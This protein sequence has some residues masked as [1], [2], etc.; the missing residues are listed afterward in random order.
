MLVDDAMLCYRMP[1]F[2]FISLVSYISKI[3]LI[4]VIFFDFSTG[5]KTVEMRF[6]LA[7]APRVHNR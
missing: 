6:C 4:F 1:L 5:L 2:S 3:S 7:K